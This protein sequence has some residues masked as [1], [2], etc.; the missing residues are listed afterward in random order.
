[1]QI[2]TG[3]GLPGGETDGLFAG[4]VLAHHSVA[5][6]SVA[7]EVENLAET[8]NN[9]AAKEAV[10]ARTPMGPHELPV[11]NQLLEVVEL[12]GLDSTDELISF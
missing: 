10:V 8:D 1:V 2:T 6:S 5:K 4:E 7:A 9:G 11:E 3:E 12:L